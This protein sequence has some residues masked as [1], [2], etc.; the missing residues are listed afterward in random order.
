V[1]PENGS[2]VVLLMPLNQNP[3]K[4]FG[5]ATNETLG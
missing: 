4:P 3:Y 5:I 1:V 2:V